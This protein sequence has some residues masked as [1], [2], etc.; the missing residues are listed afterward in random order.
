MIEKASIKNKPKVL[1]LTATPMNNTYW[2]LYFQI[3]LIARNNKRI[4]FKEG[5]FDLERQFKKADKKTSNIGDVLQIISIRRPRQ[6]IIENYPD[7]KYKDEQGN[8]V[9]IEFPERKLRDVNYSLDDTYQGLYYKIADKIEKELNLAYYRLEEYRILGKKDEMELGRMK[10]LGGILQTILLKRLESSVE[11]FRKSIQTQINFLNKF[12]EFFKDGK[13]LRKKFYDKYLFYLEGDNEI[14]EDIA[15]EIDKNLETINL[16]EF[17]K[18]I[19]LQDLQDDIN[20]FKE[21]EKIVAPIDESQDAKLQEL[22]D[23]LIKLKPLGKI[24]L[25]SFYAD[26]IDYLHKALEKDK[27]FQK[28]YLKKFEKITGSYSTN[29][30]KE[31]VDEFLNKD[32]DLLL[33]TDILSEGQNLQKARIVLNYDLHWNPVRM[34]QRA[35]RID[36]IGSPYKEIYIYNFYPEKELESLLELVKILQRKIEMINETVGLDASVLGEKIN[37]K[38]FGIIRELKGKE[39]LSD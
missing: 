34:I 5:I 26:T 20:I 24:I 35:G 6:Y 15:S 23:K 30:R 36:R 29:K 14:R 9:K 8:W 39:K 32:I 33:S 11:S 4:F 3:M 27:E 28:F 17:D 18:E 10:A 1:L 22:K 21:L 13:I 2:D 31:I 12:K 16:N 7:A 38:V 25:F 37:P 19:F